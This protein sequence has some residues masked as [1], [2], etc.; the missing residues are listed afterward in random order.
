[1]KGFVLAAGLGTRLRPLTDELPKPLFPIARVPLVAF[2]LKLLARHGI[3]QVAMNLHHLGEAVERAVGDGAAFGVHVT[4][5]REQPILGTGGGLQR[6]R[7]WLDETFVVVNSDIVLDH[8]VAGLARRH[9]ERGAL[10]TMVLRDEAG[11]RDVEIDRDGLVH[12][13]VG[14]GAATTASL[15]GYGFTGVHVLEPRLLDYLPREGVSCVIRQ[16]YAP[17]LERG[18]RVLSER[19]TGYWADAGT[20]ERY[21]AVTRDVLT[22]AARFAHLDPLEGTLEREP[23][24]HVHPEAQVSPEARLMGPCL[25][26]AR[27]V[28]EARA[29]VGPGA[30]VSADVVVEA[31]A[32][33]TN[34]VLLARAR[35]RRGAQV[36]GAVL[37]ASGARCAVA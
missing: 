8:D 18:E 25:V 2:A 23:T 10:A 24:V 3:R 36:A 28:I 22:G 37:S 34:A 13:V 27:A 15:G 19:A 26:D 35:V 9:A 1:M 33:L 5:S 31:D 7:A 21:L 30:V 32:V 14:R 20:P 4:Y 11:V 29:V 16:G 17:A 6:M 12:R